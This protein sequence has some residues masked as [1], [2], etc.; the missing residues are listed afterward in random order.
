[1]KR[2]FSI[3]WKGS[4]QPRKQRKYRNNAPSHIKNKFLSAH[5]SKELRKKHNTRNITLKKGDKVKIV[6]GQFKGKT[7]AV[8]RINLKKAKVYVTGVDVIK[9]DG[10]K[11]SYQIDPSNLIIT[12]FDLD[13]KARKKSIERVNKEK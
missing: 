6:R 2:K 11:R 12:D 8:D 4:K 1:M 3:D 10:T 5:L 9:K 7:G 13:D